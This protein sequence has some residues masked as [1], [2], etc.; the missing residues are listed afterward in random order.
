MDTACDQQPQSTH[1]PTVSMLLTLKAPALS[2][3]PVT[4]QGLH[5]FW[6]PEADENHGTEPPTSS[7]KDS[8]AMIYGPT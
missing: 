5:Q 3:A 6:P 2:T 4:S 8:G 7:N 1:F